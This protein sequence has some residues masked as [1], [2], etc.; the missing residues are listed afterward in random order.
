M[1]VK[2]MICQGILAGK[3]SGL[4]SSNTLGLQFS[5]RHMKRMSSGRS[6]W[7]P[8]KAMVLLIQSVP[9][10]LL[11]GSKNI[12]VSIPQRHSGFGKSNPK[13]IYFFSSQM[14]LFEYV[15]YI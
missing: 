14:Y 5:C 7:R 12:A 13:Q 15:K 10:G 8:F 6:N 11:A 1:K 3:L 9:G 2:K 4:L